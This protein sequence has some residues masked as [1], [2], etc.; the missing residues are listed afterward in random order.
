MPGALRWPESPA[1]PPFPVRPTTRLDRDLTGEVVL[2]YALQAVT[3]IVIGLLL[4]SG[5]SGDLGRA[6]IPDAVPWL[7]TPLSVAAQEGDR[8]GSDLIRI[9]H[10][11]QVAEARKQFEGG[12]RHGGRH[13][14]RYVRATKAVGL[15]PEEQRGRLHPR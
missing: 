14:P 8:S 1:S 6:Q 9:I 15:T 11:R 13:A 4:V 2:G 3:C 5:S 7:Q 12:I 10:P